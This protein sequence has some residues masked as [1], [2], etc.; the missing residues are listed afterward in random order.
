MRRLK[1]FT[2]TELMV[3]LAVIGVIVAV[4]TP[5]I[6]RTRPNKNKMMIKK[7][8]YTAQ[9]MIN[10]L[11]ND[12]TLYPDRTEESYWGFDDT[13]KV[14]YEG[15]E[16]DGNTKF[17][18]LFKAKLNVKSVDSANNSIF[19]STDGVMWNLGG[20][21]GAWTKQ[22]KVGTFDDQTDASGIGKILVDV[23]GDEKPNC[24]EN[25]F[26]D[27]ARSVSCTGSADDFDRYVIEILVNGKMRINPEDTKAIEY[28]TINTSI[29]D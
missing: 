3:A 4:V 18:E 21:V 12:S 22:D 19:Y 8:F 16:Y 24:R 25:S 1:A 9:Q 11:I 23:N 6:M 10:T 15:M 27:V 28:A 20:T 7:S 2:L 13:D 17:L 29:R 14:T 26:E 5:T